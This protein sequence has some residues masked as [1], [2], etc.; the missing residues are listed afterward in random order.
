[1]V[2]CLVSFAKIVGMKVISSKARVV[3]EV[4]GI[5]I[6]TDNWRTTHLH[7]KLADEAAVQLGFKK[8]FG[9]SK[10]CLPVSLVKAVGELVTLKSSFEELSSSFNITEC[11]E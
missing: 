4:K 5:E 6:N 1:M 7:V 11:K 10:I 3:G 2:L 8:R 9:S